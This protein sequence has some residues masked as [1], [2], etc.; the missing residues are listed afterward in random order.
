MNDELR[1][2]ILIVEDDES[3]ASWI[4]DYLDSHNFD[5]CVANRGDY[6]LELIE[7]E[8]PDLVLLDINL[9]VKD[10][11]DICREA[12]VFYSRPILMMTA[13]DE[14]FDE[15]L[16]LELGADDYIT[17][18][19][20]ARALLAR[21]KGL[22][23]RSKASKEVPENN[24]C[25]VFGNLTIDRHSRTTKLKDKVINISS[26]EFNVLWILASQSGSIVSRESLIKELR[27]I[28]YDGFDRST[29]I[30]VSR[31]RK[32]LGA[33]VSS[34]QCIKTIWGKGYLFSPEPWS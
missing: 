25:L 9:P 28:E 13:R 7:V 20:R 34:E 12:R 18:P 15:V 4:A 14:E 5:V 31:L 8:N 19:I 22:L 1:K 29:D 30:L 2:S 3:L 27:G 11:F 6:A 24:D 33:H 16:G 23:R 32:K 17:K 21:I 26:N 10:G